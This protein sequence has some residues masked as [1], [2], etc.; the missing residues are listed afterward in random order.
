MAPF[1]TARWPSMPVSVAFVKDRSF[2]EKLRS[3]MLKS[4]QEWHIGDSRISFTQVDKEAQ[5]TIKFD[6]KKLSSITNTLYTDDVLTSATITMGLG[7]PNNN[8]KLLKDTD[9]VSLGAHEV[10]HALGLIGH[11]P[12][13]NDLMSRN[14]ESGCSVSKLD[15]EEIDEVYGWTSSNQNHS[16]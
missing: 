14:V 16:G 8:G 7:D 5:I 9:I 15:I 4:I 11:N 3:L 12:E 13:L 10:G 6:L 2:S 1:P